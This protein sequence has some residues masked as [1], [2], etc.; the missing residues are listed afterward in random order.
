MRILQPVTTEIKGQHIAQHWC[1]PEVE[2]LCL[3]HDCI[4]FT[5]YNS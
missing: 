2:L 1:N 4:I 5:E 3:Y